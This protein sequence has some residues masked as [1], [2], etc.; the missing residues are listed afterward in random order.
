M[1]PKKIADRYAW[2]YFSDSVSKMPNLL[3]KYIFFVK[4]NRVIKKRK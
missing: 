1:K 4:L 2:R 3:V